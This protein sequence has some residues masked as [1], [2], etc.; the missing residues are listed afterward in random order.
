MSR[1]KIPATWKWTTAE[2]IADIVAGGTPPSKDPTNFARNGISWITPADLTGY[3]HAYIGRGKRCLSEKGLAASSARVLPVG[4]VLFTS[5]APIGYCAIAENPIATN[6]GFKNLVLKNDIQPEYV[7]H[8]L[9]AS[10][11]YAE[12]ISSGTTFKELSSTRMKN[13]DIPVA[14]T[15]EQRRIVEKIDALQDRSRKAREALS[16][17]GPL[18]EQFRQSLLAA[19]FRGDLTAD[20]RAQNPNVEPA[21]ELLKRI[22]K[23]R[24]QKWEEAELAKYEAKGK[25]PPKGWQE[26]YKEPDPVDESELPELPAGSLALGIAV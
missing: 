19:A 2:K 13:F 15:G 24:R 21:S 22:R 25:Q 26:K 17:V 7:R 3:V 10:K 6:Q 18:L 16:E 12:S 8:Y 11:A 1:W 5:R 23:E 20:W 14:P 9:L 4:T